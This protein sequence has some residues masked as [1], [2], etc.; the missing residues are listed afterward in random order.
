MKKAIEIRVIHVNLFNETVVASSFF[1]RYNFENR[2]C[3]LKLFQ[4]E[5]DV[6]H[7]HTHSNK[8]LRHET[9]CV[10]SQYTERSGTILLLL[11]YA[12]IHVNPYPT[13]VEN[14]VSS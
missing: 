2:M 3:I 1:K 12:Y 4:R 7:T 10:V 11:S 13:N 14:R 6:T 5:S 9:A 8:V